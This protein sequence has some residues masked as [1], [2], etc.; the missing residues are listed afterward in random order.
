MSGGIECD[1]IRSGSFGSRIVQTRVSKPSAESSP[2]FVSRCST[3]K[4]DFLTATILR[5][6]RNQVAEAHGSM[7]AGPGLDQR[8]A[9]EVGPFQEIAFRQA[10]GLEDERGL[11]I[12]P[13]EES[14]VEYDPGGVAVAPL[15]LAAPF[16]Q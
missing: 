2:Q 16:A 9:G 6:D 8:K 5:F 13:F 1:F 12:E 14:R 7:E 3:S 4:L 11:R 10:Y 15:E